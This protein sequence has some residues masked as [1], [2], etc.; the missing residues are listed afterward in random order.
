MSLEGIFMF[1]G[2]SLREGREREGIKLQD[3]G[4]WRASSGKA[5]A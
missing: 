5:S 4:W 3:M 2:K 1:L